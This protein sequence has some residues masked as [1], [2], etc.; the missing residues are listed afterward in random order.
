MA[1][2]ED[3][4]M[5]DLRK[6]I[7]FVKDKEEN[8]IVVLTSTFEKLSF[9]VGVSKAL[10]GKYKAGNLVKIAAEIT[11]GKGGGKPDF[12]QAGGKDKSK[13]EEAMEAIKKAIKE[14]K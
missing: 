12:A 10:T 6:M 2:Y 7:D 13:I 4:S 11:G 8:A 3:K 14:N 5:D 9:A 1:K